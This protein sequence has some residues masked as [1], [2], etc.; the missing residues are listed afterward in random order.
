MQRATDWLALWRELAEAQ[1][2]GWKETH[3]KQVGEDAWRD[4][5]RDYDARTKRRWA[6]SDSSRDFVV[7]QLRAN[8]G[9]TALD[10]GGGTGSWTALMARYARQVTAVEPSAAMSEVM[11]ENVRAENLRNVEIV[12]GKWPDVQVDAH[13]LT[14][15]AHAMYGFPDLSAFVRSIEAV[16]RRMCVLVMRAPILDSL[17]G[18]AAE[19]IWGQPYD[20]P[21]FQVAYNALLQ[22]GVF[23]N[24]LMESSGLWDPWRSANFDEAFAE[25]K[26]RF[27]VSATTEHDAF[28]WDLLKQNLTLEGG[29]CLWPRGIRSALVYWPVENKV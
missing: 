16:T 22:M 15:C 27:N 25:M 20:S 28:L 3:A 13:D 12:S 21:D 17:M 9:W 18:R 14:L 6:T 29:Q 26:R 8:P 2:Q 19:R 24:V 4:R 11:Q 1:A 10:I 5:A 23:A 7:S